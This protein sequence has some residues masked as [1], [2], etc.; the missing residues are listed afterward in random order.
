MI[1]APLKDF[2]VFTRFKDCDYIGLNGSTYS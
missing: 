1:S 2:Q